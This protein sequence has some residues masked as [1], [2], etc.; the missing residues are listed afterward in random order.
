MA[1]SLTA[2]NKPET[3][4]DLAKSRPDETDVVWFVRTNNDWTEG[5]VIASATWDQVR[6]TL[7]DR[8]Q[9]TE[10]CTDESQ[11]PSI[12]MTASRRVQL[13]AR[14]GRSGHRLRG[15]VMDAR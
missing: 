11:V 3:G 12:V 10:R 1:Q 13:G 9:S 7:G 4:P 8:L 6:Q 14:R 2:I 5:E 15:M